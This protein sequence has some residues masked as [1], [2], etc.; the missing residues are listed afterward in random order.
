MAHAGLDTPPLAA[1]RPDVLAWPS[2]TI[3][4]Y[5]VFVTALLSSGLFVGGWVHNQTVGQEWARTYLDCQAR[6]GTASTTFSDE[7]YAAQ[8]AVV[9]CAA[10]VE[11]TRALMTLGGAGVAALLGL[12]IV[13]VAPLVIQRRRRLRALGTPLQGAEDQFRLLVDEAGLKV[14]VRP[15]VGRAT[16]RDAF[17]IGWPGRYTVA[18]PPAVVVRWRDRSLFDP[19]VSH[20]LA[21]LRHGDVTLAWLTRSVWIALAP[22]LL[23]PGRRRA[24]DLGPLAAP[25]VRLAC[26]PPRGRRGPGLRHPAQVA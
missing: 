6:H 14:R 7:S 12:C 25:R 9:D 11:R 10:D 21:H 17:S 23:V 20:E 22:L 24:G 2:P 4:R 3:S 5:L 26:R 13:V 1:A 15:M 8:Q 19:V 16:Q 18:L